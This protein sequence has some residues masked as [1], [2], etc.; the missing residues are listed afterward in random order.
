MYPNIG[1]C[2]DLTSRINNL[3]QELLKR[4]HFMC[5]TE[6]RRF[7][8]AVLSFHEGL[9]EVENK[10]KTARN[11]IMFDTVTK[12]FIRNIHLKVTAM[13][14]KLAKI[15]SSF[16]SKSPAG[17]QVGDQ[18]YPAKQSE[19]E[20]NADVQIR[21]QRFLIERIES[22]EILDDICAIKAE[23]LYNHLSQLYD[24]FISNQIQIEA[25]TDDD[26]TLDNQQKITTE[27]QRKVIDFQT[28]LKKLMQPIAS[29]SSTESNISIDRSI[30]PITIDS[31]ADLDSLFQ[32]QESLIK[33]ISSLKPENLSRE[34]AEVM[35]NKHLD[36]LYESFN[37]N[38]TEIESRVSG[39]MLDSQLKI[40]EQVQNNVIELEAKFK[41]I[42]APIKLSSSSTQSEALQSE[43][44][45]LS[46]LESSLRSIELKLSNLTDLLESRSSRDETESNINDVYTH[47]EDNSEIS[48]DIQN[49]IISL[50][51]TLN[52]SIVVNKNHEKNALN[53]LDKIL[54]FNGRFEQDYK[55]KTLP[56]LE[57]S[58]SDLQAIE[59]KLSELITSCENLPELLSDGRDTRKNISKISSSL[60]DHL[61]V[62]QDIQAQLRNF[63]DANKNRTAS[64]DDNQTKVNQSTAQQQPLQPLRIEN[65]T[66]K[67][68][69]NSARQKYL[70]PL[71][72]ESLLLSKERPFKFI[73]P[74]PLFH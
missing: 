17:A 20:K 37:A 46:E 38:Q 57:K 34:K 4:E 65:L 47:L 32:K 8:E 68:N 55:T 29:T 56:S 27:I 36:S 33:R 50:Q 23:V 41:K 16:E 69:Q 28:K 18:S 14:I 39:P 49:K 62:S 15:I 5:A 26:T 54:E 51:T 10:Q 1:I 7:Y 70:Q 22:L 73:R 66:T 25:G 3:E 48:K 6:A 71:R 61:N 43:Q 12:S 64:L 74:K 60:N 11:D 59:L 24:S 30:Q 63:M 9:V 35:Y 44:I 45:K 21:K 2:Q 40:S 52:E 19:T 72:I 67:V 53:K 31:R 58:K 42:I 13:K